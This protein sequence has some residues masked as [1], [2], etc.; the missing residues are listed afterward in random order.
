MVALPDK[1]AVLFATLLL[2]SGCPTGSGDDDSAAP[3][4][5]DDSTPLDDDDTTEPPDPLAPVI[6]V[7][8]LT[9]VVR[10]GGVSY[11][12]LSGAFGQFAEMP[13]EVFAPAS[14]LGLDYGVDAPFWRSDLG[15]WPL[16]G[17]GEWEFVDLVYYYPWTAPELTWW[18]GGVRVGVGAYLCSQRD[19]DHVIAYEVDD[20][21]SPGAA[22]WTPGGTLGWENAGGLDVIDFVAPDAI[23][24]PGEVVMVEP[25]AGSE[26]QAPAALDYAVRWQP[27]PDG[28]FV[29]IGLLSVDDF[30]YIA[31]VSDDGEHVIPASVLHDDFG[32]GT[33]EL[34]VARNLETPL[35]HPQGDILFRSRVERRATLEL[36]PDV[37]LDPPFAEPG[38]SV[39]VDLSWFTQDLSSGLE[40]DFGEGIVVDAVVPDPSDV[41]RALVSLHVLPGA[42]PGGR[43]VV[44]TLPGGDPETAWSG[45]AVLSLLPSDDCASADATPPLTPGVYW[46]TTVGLGNDQ[47]SGLACL[48]WSL[49]GADA[50]YRV[51]LEPNDTLVARL[52]EPSPGDGAL[53][54][55]SS[56]GDGSSAV[57]CADATFEGEPEALVY[58]S[59]GGGTHYLVIDAWSSGGWGFAAAWQ[60]ELSIEQDVIDPD[61]IV[62]GSSRAFVLYGETPWDAGILPVDIDLGVG[63]A[64][65]AV[66]VGSVNTELEFL[67][68][69]AGA[70]VPGPRDITVDNGAAGPVPF[71]EAY[72]VTGWPAWD[73][74][75]EATVGSPLDPGTATGYGVEAT[76]T[77]DD[78]PCMPFLSVG[79]EILL[80]LE[81]TAGSLLDVAVTMPEEDAQLYILADCEQPESCFED[82][83]ADGTVEGEQ[84]AIVDWPVPATGRYYVVVD[85]YGGV[86]NPLAPWQF[87]LA[88]TVH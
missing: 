10:A 82:A 60:L 86:L 84:E 19:F 31:H 58:T 55:L 70:A 57:A 4:D 36:L 1:P 38:Q 53:Y 30:A 8:N 37:V 83:V 33:L 73:S 34:V 2:L 25:L 22:G 20:P 71:Y 85:I 61:W 27:G 49:N 48:A 51:E 44:L 67:A 75:A 68:T 41:H 52:D 11:V 46:S 39:D 18:D 88:I 56:C 15:A 5:D 78:V 29:T 16:P 50:V 63:V 74:C 42:A 77:I 79:P 21:I 81:L 35:A 47:G 40:V 9:G 14:Y 26:V 72:W 80:P 13:D 3:V 32:A 54:L 87:D 65:G 64:A 12:D 23:P 6:G 69:A 24:L 7:F 76:G 28:A 62:P 17:Q 43:D 59:A 66:A 45:F